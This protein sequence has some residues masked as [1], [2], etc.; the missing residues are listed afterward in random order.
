[1]SIEN[2][3]N[4]KN[5]L[6]PCLGNTLTYAFFWMDTCQGISL[7]ILIPHD[8]TTNSTASFLTVAIGVLSF[9]QQRP[10]LANLHRKKIYW[11]D[12]K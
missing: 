10:T 2:H 6:Q 11:K 8:V 7:E 5:V 1:M 4:L 9:K 3:I 12:L